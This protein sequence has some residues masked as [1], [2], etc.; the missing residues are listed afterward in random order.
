MKREA[1]SPSDDCTCQKTVALCE[2]ESSPPLTLRPF[3]LKT[4]LV[5]GKF[6]LD[7]TG[8]NPLSEEATSL[9]CV[10]STVERGLRWEN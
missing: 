4:I 9:C 6:S 2:E 3:I 1:T 8:G 10:A 7:L 5:W